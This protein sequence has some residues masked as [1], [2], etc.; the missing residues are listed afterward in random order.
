MVAILCHIVR[1]NTKLRAASLRA[2]RELYAE[3]DTLP[4]TLAVVAKSAYSARTRRSVTGFLLGE[5]APTLLAGESLDW[6]D[7][8]TSS[9][10]NGWFLIYAY[11]VLVDDV[12]DGDSKDRDLVTIAAGTLLQRGVVRILQSVQERRRASLSKAID[13]F[14]TETASGATAELQQ[15]HLRSDPATFSTANFARK[16]AVLK[17]CAAQIAVLADVA[18]NEVNWPAVEKLAAGVQL[19]DDVTDWREDWTSQ[20]Y[21]YLIALTTQRLLARGMRLEQGKRSA[22][23]FLLSALA[24]GALEDVVEKAA[25]ELREALAEYRPPFAPTARAFISSRIAQ[26]VSVRRSLRHHRL[27]AHRLVGPIW[28]SRDIDAELKTP[29]IKKVLTQTQKTLQVVAQSS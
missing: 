4:Q 1:Q 14:L 2:R 5:C 11:I 6:T 7:S 15:R 21:T 16:L 28:R 24:T 19:L 12:I 17:L 18:D 8:R 25:S 27:V 9:A 3:I 13:R 10:L 23:I 20:G 26:L 22:G 29:R